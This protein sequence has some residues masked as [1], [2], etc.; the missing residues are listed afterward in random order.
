MSNHVG[1]RTITRS[2][3]P[4][5]HGTLTL[6][7]GGFVPHRSD[8]GAITSES[9]D[10]DG[11]AGPGPNKLPT[12]RSK[13]Q[14]GGTQS[15]QVTV[16]ICSQTWP[17][18][19]PTHAAPMSL[20]MRLRTSHCLMAEGGSSQI[21]TSS[22]PLRRLASRSPLRSRRGMIPVLGG[23]KGIR[24]ILWEVASALCND[25]CRRTPDG[26]FY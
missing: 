18:I 2:P 9:P 10:R 22:R 1:I 12:R 14:I 26:A 17:V 11:G 13:V 5:A 3:P 19:R 6:N 24:P 15:S 7:L 8:V 25:T 23:R 16:S 21:A 4:P 20:A